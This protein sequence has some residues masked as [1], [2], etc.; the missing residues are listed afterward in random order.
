MSRTKEAMMIVLDAG[1]SMREPLNEPT[2]KAVVG[3]RFDAAKTAVQSILSQKMLFR[4]HD[5]VGI[6]MYGTEGTDNHLHETQ[7]GYE[8]V[9]VLSNLDEVSTRVAETMAVAQAAS[10]DTKADV[11]DGIIVALDLLIRRTDKKKY[12]KRL[13]VVTDA[14]TPIAN[15]ADMEVVCSMVQNMDVQLQIIGID[16]SITDATKAEPLAV[17]P[18]ETHDIK[19]ENEKM[20]LSIVNEVHGELLSVSK[21]I[22]FL[23]QGK[24]KTVNQT[25]KFRGNLEFG[26]TLQI[27]TYVFSKTL[28]QR[29]PTL[30]KESTVGE[31][32]VGKVKMDR[33]YH[34]QAKPDEEVAPEARI[35]A[36]KY[37]SEMIPFSTAD[38]AS[39]KL[40]TTRSL[41]ILGFLPRDCVDR[42]MF[43]SNTDAVFGDFTKPRAQEALAALVRAMAD[44]NKVA[45]ARFVARANA[46]PKVVVLIP[47]TCSGKDG[48]LHCLWL[49]QIPFE[50]DMRQYEF[51]SLRVAKA[52][53]TKE[54]Q[55]VAD[56]LVDALMLPSDKQQLHS[57]AFCPSL[58]RFYDTIPKRAE[59]PQCP[60]ASLPPYV[61]RYLREDKELF[62]TA[63]PSIQRFN[64]AFQL[65]EAVKAKDQ[66]K[67]F[68]WS[69]AKKNEAVKDEPLTGD[70]AE[71]SGGGDDDDD[72]FDLD[73]LLGGEDVT[74]VGSMNPIS[75]FEAL[76]SAKHNKVVK[77]HSA[78]SGMQDQISTLFGQESAYHGKA[79][80]CLLHFRRRSPEI[81]YTA[82]FNAFLQT[83]KDTWYLSPVWSLL[84]AHN[85]TLLSTKDDP[86][87]DV[88][89]TGAHAFL[90]GVVAAPT[91]VGV[92]VDAPAPIEDDDLF[93]DLE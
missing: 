27:P 38:Q 6:V 19:L 73:D 47:N 70:D 17:K 67:K 85:V 72:E 16:F 5:E 76:L 59:D 12:E 26:A 93:A 7:G 88:T 92:A 42:S 83:L 10:K 61:E 60:V 15:P 89:P 77:A 87:T 45:I 48:R 68:F 25:T 34:S 22:D 21:R 75:D 24:T 14:A 39:L 86:T 80:Q 52:T 91:E 56:A 43:M 30:A 13:V 57:K 81:H 20:L 29:L 28:E 79:L 64:A 40:E 63:L 51:P 2:R 54:Q 9:H 4:K 65:K 53:P 82:S 49:Q 41:K 71:P 32:G 35:K 84:V 55:D 3:S 8:H 58:Q 44:E 74:S 46:A 36:Y 69:D 37:G 18:E 1:V 33:L 50:E 90:H 62:T 78:V 66:K 11:L 31:P 23:T